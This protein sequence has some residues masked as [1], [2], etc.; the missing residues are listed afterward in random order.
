MKQPKSYRVMQCRSYEQLIACC[1]LVE[2]TIVP[3]DKTA[4]GETQKTAGQ[5]AAAA[6]AQTP[7][8]PGQS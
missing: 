6:A 3:D 4:L 2:Y 1:D 5:N 8:G 7:D